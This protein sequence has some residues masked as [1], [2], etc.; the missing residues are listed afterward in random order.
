MASSVIISSPNPNNALIHIL[1]QAVD[2][3]G[4]PVGGASSFILDDGQTWTG[5]IDPHTV[6][7]LQEVPRNSVAPAPAVPPVAAPE[8]VPEAPIPVI[9]G[10]DPN[11]PVPV[12]GAAPIQE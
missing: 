6:I 11:Q 9:G 8:P 7:M 4:G 1:T 12:P 10:A 5:S 3:N 2:A